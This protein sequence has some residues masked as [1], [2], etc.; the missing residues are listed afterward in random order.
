M[1]YSTRKPFNPLTFHRNPKS[2]S[3]HIENEEDDEQADDDDDVKTQST[4][5]QNRRKLRKLKLQILSVSSSSF[6]VMQ[7]VPCTGFKSGA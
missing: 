5:R 3:P 1:P 4:F 2:L 6:M 7:K